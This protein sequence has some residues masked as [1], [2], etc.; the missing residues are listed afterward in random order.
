MMPTSGHNYANG[1]LLVNTVQ[2]VVRTDPVTRTLYNTVQ[3]FVGAVRP[4]Q[5]GL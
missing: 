5:N 3:K 4:V 1:I 2:L